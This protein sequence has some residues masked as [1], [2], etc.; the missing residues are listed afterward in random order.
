G[1]GRTASWRNHGGT[2]RVASCQ[3]QYRPG[4]GYGRIE[5]GPDSGF[6]HPC[7]GTVVSV[8]RPDKGSLNQRN[9][10]RSMTTVHW[11]LL[12]VLIIVVGGAYWYLRRHNGSDP[13]H[14]MEE[15]DDAD[16]VS[17]MSLGGD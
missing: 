17:G 8:S 15:P 16:G 10:Q 12:I 3:C 11:I 1:T 13:W 6:V 5:V 2:W 14:G 7:H 9:S 4:S